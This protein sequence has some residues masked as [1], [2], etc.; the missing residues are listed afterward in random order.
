M[1]RQNGSAAQIVRELQGIAAKV[2][3]ERVWRTLCKACPRSQ[4]DHRNQHGDT[5][6]ARVQSEKADKSRRRELT[7]LTEQSRCSP[8]KAPTVRKQ[9]S[10]QKN[11]PVPAAGE[12]PTPSTSTPF[13]IPTR[14]L[15]QTN[16][17]LELAQLDAV[18]GSRSIVF[19]SADNPAP[20][21][22][23]IN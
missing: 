21:S 18:V 17:L 10:R 11:V 14:F 22:C 20:E 23:D 19:V 9:S 5:Q 4:Q 2:C 1:A 16:I 3:G 15:S 13:Q 12:L 8:R 7:K 6:L